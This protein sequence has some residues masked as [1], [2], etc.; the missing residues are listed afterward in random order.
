MGETAKT[1]NGTAPPDATPADVWRER[2]IHTVTLPSGSVAKIRIPGIGTI[3]AAGELPTHL[4]G[5]ALLD[6]SH[7]TGAA[8][9][10]QEALAD[11]LDE[12]KREETLAE[13]QKLHEYRCRIVAEALIDPALTV[14]EVMSGE[15]PEDD[16]A[17][18]AAIVQRLR[19]FDAKG[20]RIGVEPLDRWAMFHREHGLSD[21]DEC[22]HC[23]RITAEFSSIDVGGV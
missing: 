10:L 19:A 3:L 8:S 6:M 11:T 9:A 16:L 20:V 1:R 22:A 15:Y 14:E 13:V 23:K 7:P 17:M 21:E 4:I 18:I 5:L 2:T 12:Q